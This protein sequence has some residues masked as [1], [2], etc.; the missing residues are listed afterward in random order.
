MLR[1]LL[2]AL[3]VP[4][5]AAEQGPQEV[6][7]RIIT[8]N[9]QS[10]LKAV[11]QLYAEDAIL[12]PPKGPVVEGR[13]AILARYEESFAML[14]LSY[15]FEELESKRSGDWAYSRGFTRGHA[16]PKDGT[17]G[18]TIYDK[19]LM[20]LHRDHGQWRIARLMWNPAE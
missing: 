20:I 16:T 9:N 17:P 6:L 19:Y 3:T 15:T 14:T 5:V 1:L 4:V 10:D 13:K 18:R 12:L 11:G 2:F 7:R 8:A